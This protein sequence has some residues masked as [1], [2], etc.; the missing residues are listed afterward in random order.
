MYF[1]LIE[2]VFREQKLPEDFKYLVLQESALIGDAVSSSNAVGYWQFKDFTGLEVGLKIDRRIDE[3][4]HIVRASEGAA[5]YLKTNNAFFDNWLYALQAYQM[6]RGG[7][8]KVVDKREYGAKKMNLDADLY[9]YVKKFLAHKIAFEYGIKERMQ[10]AND[11]VLVE[12]YDG[13][14][15]DLSDVSKK[16]KVSEEQLT[17]YN[18]WL[19]RGN[20]PDDK[21]LALLV[22]VSKDQAKY[23][24]K[25]ERLGVPEPTVITA[26]NKIK[27]KRRLDPVVGIVPARLKVNGREA[28]VAESGDTFEWLAVHAAI[29]LNRFLRYNDIDGDEKIKNGQIFYT[30]RKKGRANVHYHTLKNDESLWEVSQKYGIR[31]KSLLRKNRLD[32]QNDINVKPG[33][34]VWLRDKRP[35]DEPYKYKQ[36]QDLIPVEDTNKTILAKKDEPTDDFSGPL[37]VNES[38]KLAVNENDKSIDEDNFVKS[39][40]ISFDKPENQN[41]TNQQ[42]VTQ[43]VAGNSKN[44]E[45]G[46]ILEFNQNSKEAEVEEV[47]ESQVTREIVLTDEPNLTSDST[48]QEKRE[49]ATNK[50]EVD[51][52]VKNSIPTSTEEVSHSINKEI[53]VIAVDSLQPKVVVN[54][55]GLDVISYGSNPMNRSEQNEE[56]IKNDSRATEE[57]DFDLLE[58]GKSETNKI[59]EE[60]KHDI[61]SKIIHSV[62]KGETYYSISRKYDVTVGELLRKNSLSIDSVLSIGQELKIPLGGESIDS[63]LIEARAYKKMDNSKKDNPSM[64]GYE[65]YIVKKGDS[66]YKIARENDVTIQQVMD[67]NGKTDFDISEGEELK[68]K[69]VK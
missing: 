57:K 50:D 31:L 36:T 33:L 53:P 13:A 43:Q 35:K 61:E 18:K 6:G 46:K 48:I 17:T 5:K 52:P 60:D 49:I 64:S 10:P 29:P 14:G 21:K 30:E 24:I 39:E 68:I 66:L 25:G 38:G 67:W 47:E 2:R 51:L 1:P 32:G 44:I 62:V 8:E 58:N 4:M 28:I 9:W 37:S 34:I 65:V 27:S 42:N 54:E 41:D 69:K 23:Y 55:D 22:P 26:S 59:T 63:D 20:I 16:L 56:Q 40:N 45:A 19:R 7:A 3:R 15:L 11:L 12:Y